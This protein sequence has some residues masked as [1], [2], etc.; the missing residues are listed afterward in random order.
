ME[1]DNYDLI[2][3]YF[4]TSENLILNRINFYCYFRLISNLEQII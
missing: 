2:I 1:L 4:L 3:I